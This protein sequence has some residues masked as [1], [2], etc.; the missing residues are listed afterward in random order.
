M[1]RTYDMAT[2]RLTHDSGSTTQATIAPEWREATILCPSLA[3]QE[4]PMET[5]DRGNMPADL[6]QTPVGQFLDRQK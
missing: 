3:L 4:L 6:A 2:G 5:A 1:V